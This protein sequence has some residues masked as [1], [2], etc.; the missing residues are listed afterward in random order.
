MLI[1]E[2]GRYVSRVWMLGGRDDFDVLMHLSRLLPAGRW[3]F[4]YRFRY[5]ADDRA[6]DSKDKKSETHFSISGDVSE[7]DALEKVHEVVAVLARQAGLEV[8]EVVIES[9]EPAVFIERTENK[10]WMNMK[11]EPEGSAS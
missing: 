4:Q 7:S 6:F 5:Y 11:F 9:D 1:L 8:D 3:D 2:K 10:S